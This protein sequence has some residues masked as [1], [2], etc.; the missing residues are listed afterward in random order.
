[1]VLEKG[2]KLRTKLESCK[3]LK[4]FCVQSETHAAGDMIKQH[5]TIGVVVEDA[6]LLEEFV[7]V[8][9]AEK[10]LVPKIADT[11]V[12]FAPGDDVYFDPDGVDTGIG[13]VTND[14]ELECCGRAWQSPETLLSKCSSICS[15]CIL[16]PLLPDD[17]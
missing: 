15:R 8:Y 7:L 4:T 3:S 2:M 13:A 10:I 14:D 11:G 6:A 9:A 5:D 12:S 16:I 17:R 1:M